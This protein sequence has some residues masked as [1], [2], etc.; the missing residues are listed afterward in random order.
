MRTVLDKARKMP[1][2]TVSH[3]RKKVAE[4]K[5][6]PTSKP[7]EAMRSKTEE[8]YLNLAVKYPDKLNEIITRVREAMASLILGR[9]FGES[10]E[11]FF[12]RDK[13][14]SRRA[15]DLEAALSK[16][17]SMKETPKNLGKSKTWS[18]YKLQGR[19][20]FQGLPISIENERGTMRRG[21]D[22]DGH[23][24][25]TFMHIPYGYIRLT[26]GTDGDH[27][28]CYIG[29][30]GDAESVFVV[31]Q[32]DPTTGRY[33]EDKVML[34]FRDAMSAKKA[35]IRQY[36]R[37]GFFGTMDEYNMA[38]FKELLDKREGVKLKKSLR[39]AGGTPEGT[40]LKSDD[41][42]WYTVVGGQWT[43]FYVYSS[44]LGIL[45][46]AVTIKKYYSSEEVKAR[47]MRWVT[48]RGARVLIQ[49]TADGGWVVVGG[50][51]GKLNHMRVDKILGKEAY[52][53]KR[54]GMKEQAKKEL[55][56]LSKEELA[57]QRAKRRE[58]VKVKRQIRSGY[59][60]QV[61]KIMGIT[62]EDLRSQI[63]GKMMDEITDRAR[64]IV[65][66]RK[67]KVLDIGDEKDIE[68]EKERIVQQ[69]VKKTIKN[70]ERRA[71][72]VL[73]NDYEG[74]ANPNAVKKTL[75]GMLDKDKATE[76]L[77]VRQDFKK[78][79]KKVGITPAE[80]KQPRL[81]IGET[82][83][84][85]SGTTDEEILAE[86]K[87]Q[88]ETAKNITLYDKMNAQSQS[89]QKYV[90]QGNA[91]TVNGIISDVFGGGAVFGP[92]SFDELGVE[93]IART[94]A[95]YIQQEGRAKE[96]KA[97][98]EKFSAD[99]REK[100][101]TDALNSAEE[102]FK[103]ADDLRSLAKTGDDDAEGFMSM[104]QANGYALKEMVAA[105]QELGSAVGSLQ[106]MAH[107]INALEDPPADAV[108]VDVG[109]DLHRAR[110]R[111]KRAGLARGDY[112]IRMQK[113][114]KGK[115][116]I[117][118][119]PKES[120][121]GFIQ[122]SRDMQKVETKLD[123][124]KMHKENTG[125]KP[126]GMKGS[127][128]LKASQEAGLHFFKERK[129]VL[130]DFEAGLGKTAVGYAAAMEA[131][132]NM[133]AK[134]VLVITPAKLRNQFKDDAKVF[135]EP[136][137]QKIV[138]NTG[139]MKDRKTRLETYKRESG[140]DIIGHDTLV[141]DAGAL[142]AAGYDMVIVDEIHEMTPQGKGVG[143]QRYRGMLQ[144]RDIPMKIGMSGT[145]IKNSK[146]EL[147]RK[148]DFIDP[149]HNLG[150]M[151]D[152]EKKYTGLNQGTSAFQESSNDAFRKEVSPYMYTQRNNLDVSLDHS[153]ERVPLTKMQRTRMREI[154]KTYMEEKAAKV[155]GA[156]A[157]RDADLYRIV[158]DDAFADNSKAGR[159]VDL[160]KTKHAG[161]KAVIHVQG[162]QALES[163]KQRIEAEFGKGTVAVIKGEGPEANVMAIKKAKTQFNDPDS[164]IR[165]IIGTK[166]MEAGH[167]LQGGTVVF[168]LDQPDTYASVDQRIKR[169][170]RTGQDRNVAAY[171]LSGTNP[172]DLRQEDLI[173]KKKREMAIL[174]N[175]QAIE[176][177][178]GTGF[179]AYLNATEREAGIG[180]QVAAAI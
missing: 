161:E 160:M 150:T 27:V 167:N 153:K 106:A 24:W 30:A 12:K 71:L 145:N 49:G 36:D 50:A 61:Q 6:V 72:D 129:N 144:L 22:A 83:A 169:A 77:R 174:G 148:V 32:N 105:Q 180:K 65:E 175:P 44:G 82:F 66:T 126:P 79:V 48:V 104:A 157:R 75:R 131:M 116:L 52:A 168:N 155:P 16:L 94:M 62:E 56:A 8:H 132:N 135:L 35:Y 97:A 91:S 120:I 93:A 163:T 134:K 53:E 139:T 127:I 143:S 39:T 19:T 113:K 99:K 159:V 1:I 47:G 117:L 110:Q 118:E 9:N 170:Y 13:N 141:N 96:V 173:R 3:G 64:S 111:A 18:G 78:A 171:T 146:T 7:K 57:E 151:S 20:T 88:L 38:E 85:Y 34:G 138:K 4:G 152:F 109:T 137:Y 156:A 177:F 17:E 43:K 140:I 87:N 70:V 112:K 42:N 68:K 90:S 130:L 15:K 84:A 124:I 101:V 162:I 86:V 115:R 74:I 5:W 107:I 31:H 11:D 51:G 149:D 23:E 28:D 98:L 142:A 121:G 178:D 125:Y 33:D 14:A 119:V 60:E 172:L 55:R 2:G 81:K 108:L 122:S 102:R 40:L 136:E 29:T 92:N 73:M 179:L 154:M 46:K 95:V 21:E 58:E 158:Q 166:S 114:G 103:T 67:R 76:I 147:Y 80:P 54:R 10:M 128:T 25:A 165:F 176:G 59:E 69:E 89:I 63:T 37:P 164:P 123:R 41:G 133:G 26:E 45:E 100:I